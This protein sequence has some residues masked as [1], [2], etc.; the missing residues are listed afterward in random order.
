MQITDDMMAAFSF[1]WEMA[2]DAKRVLRD[3]A[4]LKAVAPGGD[5]LQPGD[6]VGGVYLVRAG[7][8]RVY[9][10]DANGREGTLY[11]IEPGQ[12]CILALNS[13]FTDIP[14]PAWAAAED[15][16]AEVLTIPGTVFRDLFA[17]DPAVQRFLFEQLSDRV[18]SLLKLLEQS[19][20]LPQ[21]DRLL[22]LL[23]AQADDNGVV[24]L[25]QEQLAH[26]LGTIR[27]VV[28]RLLRDLANQGLVSLAPR[29][30]QIADRGRIAALV[31]E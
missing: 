7:S 1:T 15:G 4:V 28:S 5:I 20:R 2:A 8:I 14:Y 23:I 18:F 9:Y 13:L 6:A 25:T 27:E 19:M 24:H 12:S 22:R 31:Q 16:G 17:R 29:R 30:I 26:H 11:W 10:L 21:Q 3:G